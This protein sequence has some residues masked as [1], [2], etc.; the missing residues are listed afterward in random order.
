MSGG[1]DLLHT[2][3]DINII[4]VDIASEVLEYTT[5]AITKSNVRSIIMIL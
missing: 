3:L 5:K 2:E 4:A 1:H